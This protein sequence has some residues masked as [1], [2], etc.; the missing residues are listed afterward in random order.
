MKNI[1]INTYRQWRSKQDSAFDIII[2][3]VW[4]A[5][6]KNPRANEMFWNLYD[7][8]IHHKEL[9]LKKLYSES[10]WLSDNVKFIGNKTS[11]KY[12]FFL[13]G[14]EKARWSN[15]GEEPLSLENRPK[16]VLLRGPYLKG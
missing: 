8:E 13:P 10:F 9:Y 6:L 1:I 4:V 15:E 14:L 2:D 11:Y 7:I 16:S 3:G 5:T 12:E